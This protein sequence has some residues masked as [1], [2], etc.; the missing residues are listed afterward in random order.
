LAEVTKAPSGADVLVKQENLLP[1]SGIVCLVYSIL[2]GLVTIFCFLG[3]GQSERWAH[4]DPEELWHAR[5]AML[6]VFSAIISEGCLLAANSASVRMVGQNIADELSLHGPGDSLLTLSMYGVK[7]AT[8]MHLW[9]HSGG[10]VHTDVLAWGGPRPVYFARFFQWSIAVPVMHMMTS[11]VFLCDQRPSVTLLRCAPSIIAAWSFVWSSWVMEVT[12]SPACRWLLMFLSL[13]GS[14]LILVD[15]CKLAYDHRKEELF[16]MKMSLVIFQ[17]VVFTWYGIVFELGRFGA[18]SCLHEHAFYAYTDATLK[19]FQ[20]ALLAMLRNRQDLHSIRRWWVAALAAGRD[21]T[22]LIQRAKVPVFLLDM[23]GCILD[24]NDNLRSL[25]GCSQEDVQ[26]RPLLDVVSALCKDGVEAALEAAL[27][28]GMAEDDFAG[29]E[30]SEGV[31]MRAEAPDGVSQLVEIS[32]PIRKNGEATTEMRQLCMTFVPKSNEEG[33]M[34]GILGI[35]QDLSEVAELRMV[36]ERKSALMAMLSHEIRSPLHGM[37]GLT[38]A[39][40]ETPAGKDMSRQLGMV[41]SCAARLLDLVTNVMDLAQSEKKRL[42]GKPIER[43]TAP[44]DLAEIADEVIVMMNMAVDKMNKPLVKSSVRLTNELAGKQLPIVPGDSYKLTQLLYNLM[45]N[46]CKFTDSGSVRISADY[47]TD[48][49][50]VEIGITDTGRG[51]SKEGQKSIFKPF[52]QEGDSDSRSFQGIGLGL[53]VCTEIAE[54]HGGCIRVES[55]LGRGSKFVVQLFCDGTLGQGKITPIEGSAIQHTGPRINPHAPPAAPAAPA[56]VPCSAAGAAGKPASAKEFMPE[57]RPLILSVDD[58]EVNQEVIQSA[59]QD[60]CDIEVA[61]CGQDALAY[62][63][64]QA[65]KKASGQ[66]GRIPDLV[67]LDIQ[68]PGMTGFEVCERIRKVFE[69]HTKMPIIMVSARTPQDATAIKGYHSGTTDFLSKPFNCSV[70]KHKVLLALKM[71]QEVRLG[72]SDLR[73]SEAAEELSVLKQEMLLLKG[74]MQSEKMRRDV[75]VERLKTQLERERRL[76]AEMEQ[77][78][79][80]LERESRRSEGDMQT[81]KMRRDLER[82]RSQT[83]E[84]EQLKSQLER[85]RRRN[86][87]LQLVNHELNNLSK[88]NMQKP[89]STC[90]TPLAGR[91]PRMEVSSMVPSCNVSENSIL[92]SDSVMHHKQVAQHQQVTMMGLSRE[93]IGAK[94]ALQATHSRLEVMNRLAAGCQDLL[95]LPASLPFSPSVD[96]SMGG[97][98]EEDEAQ[99]HLRS[100]LMSYQSTVAIVSTHLDMMQRIAEIPA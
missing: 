61:M 92:A 53:S 63:D 78:K 49:K 56:A 2:V 22:S 52:E 25:T 96:G 46:A 93:L 18:V 21:M 10:L 45:T 74:D 66:Q 19:V 87:E 36:Q 57:E 42:A 67:L 51:I 90:S 64:A 65:L 88:A 31:A 47:K 13:M 23:D 37:L 27:S 55:E 15:Q 32:I 85:E 16:G 62:L 29:G 24:W 41:R 75:E 28:A 50:I 48:Q 54:L 33:L 58:D 83:A 86:E 89:L 44:V 99:H 14:V 34:G 68:M 94:A 5:T 38:T 77:L 35:G 82:D 43:P 1:W 73:A 84:T 79:N 26:G 9:W 40:L 72:A 11:R 98:E 8:A 60:F 59:L 30:D 4:P 6:L 76:T 17:I 95:Q 69:I 97:H 12:L 71:K 70:L 20:G 80:Q 7:V 3:G 81:E 39:L 91:P 100:Q